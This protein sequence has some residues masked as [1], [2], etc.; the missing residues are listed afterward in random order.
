MLSYCHGR[1][2]NRTESLAS[3]VSEVEPVSIS[4]TEMRPAQPDR[5]II[6]D[7]ILCSAVYEVK[8]FIDLCDR[9]GFDEK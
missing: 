5:S 3:V 2:Q 8:L 6:N 7:K 1:L 4:I 9:S